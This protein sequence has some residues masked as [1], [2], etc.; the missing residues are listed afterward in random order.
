MRNAA[1]IVAALL[2]FLLAFAA[3]CSSGKKKKEEEAKPLL[4]IGVAPD[5][6]PLVFKR[7]GKIVG[8]EVDLGRLLAEEL[9]AGSVAF[10]A[11]STGVYR[12][13]LDDAAR[14]AARAVMNSSAQVPDIRFVLFDER[15]LSAFQKAFAAA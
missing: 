11:I 7:D 6:A 10:P 15:A 4:H 13:P 5:Y 3:G 8:L 9:G 2:L 14:I 1:S 12:W